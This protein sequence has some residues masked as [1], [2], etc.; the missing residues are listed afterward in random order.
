MSKFVMRNAYVA[1]NGTAL[2]DH[3]SSVELEDKADEVEFTSFGPGAYKEYGQGFHDATITCTFFSD[4]SGA[5]S[6]HAILQ[7]LY[8]SGGTFSVE[9]RADS[10]AR[11][12]ANP[13]ATMTARLYAYSGISGKVGDAATMDCAFR[14]AGTAGLVW[15]T[16]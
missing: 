13:A 11:G 2:S 6:P 7:P 1:I 9:V 15:A 3:A 14:N 16:S 5:S 12:T 4:F 8:S 10:G